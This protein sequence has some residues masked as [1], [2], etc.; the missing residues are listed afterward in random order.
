LKTMDYFL[1]FL[2][3]FPDLVQFDIHESGFTA[4][5]LNSSTGSS[6]K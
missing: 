5:T 4:R 1:I 6:F 3:A 2:C